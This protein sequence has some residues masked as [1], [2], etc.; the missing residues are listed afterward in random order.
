[1]VNQELFYDVFNLNMVDSPCHMI[2]RF[3]RES[4]ITE[5]INYIEDRIILLITSRYNSFLSKKTSPNSW[6]SLDVLFDTCKYKNFDTRY[7]V[8]NILQFDIVMKF[9]VRSC[10]KY[11]R[12]SIFTRYTKLQDALGYKKDGLSE[13]IKDSLQDIIILFLYNYG[14]ERNYSAYNINYT[15]INDCLLYVESRKDT[16]RK[17]TKL[18]KKK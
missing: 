12:D 18:I 2:L 3:K 1:M 8:K 16:Q 5:Y 4:Q 10:Y 9:Y 17:I 7:K 15:W 6:K 11:K 13:G 14:L